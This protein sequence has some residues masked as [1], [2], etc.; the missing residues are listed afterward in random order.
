MLAAEE[1]VRRLKDK[2]H[3]LLEWGD[4]LDQELSSDLLT[5]M[6]ENSFSR[7]FWEEQL[8]A[9][10]TKDGRQVRWHLLLIKW[11]LNLTSSAYHALMTGGFVKLPSERTLRDYVHYFV[12]QT[13]LSK[14]SS[15]TAT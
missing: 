7:L 10:S 4:T 2:V 15:E 12:K 6:N 9:A 3:K 1:E 5:I 8:K 11:C 13:W 14:G